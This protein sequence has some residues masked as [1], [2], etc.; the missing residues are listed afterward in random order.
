MPNTSVSY[1]KLRSNILKA[2]NQLNTNGWNTYLNVVNKEWASVAYSGSRILY[3]MF[4]QTIEPVPLEIKLRALYPY[5]PPPKN[6]FYLTLEVVY[7]FIL[8]SRLVSK[9][10]LDY[11]EIPLG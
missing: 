7:E 6:S 1:Q 2:R 11:C 8:G 5:S 3:L 10:Y 9:E 4:L